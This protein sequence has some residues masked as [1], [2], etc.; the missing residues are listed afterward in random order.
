MMGGWS[1]MMNGSFGGGMGW[2]GIILILIISILIIIGIVFL[3]VWLVKR[4][5]RK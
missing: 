5:T 2:T 1:N 4:T 3:I